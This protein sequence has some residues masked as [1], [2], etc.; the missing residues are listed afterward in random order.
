MSTAAASTALTIS[1]WPVPLATAPAC[2]KCNPSLLNSPPSSGKCN[3]SL[4]NSPPSSGKCIPSLLNIPPPS[5][6]SSTPIAGGRAR[7]AAL[8]LGH[9]I[10]TPE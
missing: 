10:N 4:L 5:G 6:C 7:P 2:G 9:W 1:S 8:S 3:P